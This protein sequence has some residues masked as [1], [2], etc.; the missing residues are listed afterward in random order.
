MIL[1]K[2]ILKDVLVPEIPQAAGFVSMGMSVEV[3]SP[4]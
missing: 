3:E 4:V 1:S 2:D